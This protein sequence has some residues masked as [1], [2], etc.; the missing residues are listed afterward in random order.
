MKSDT[1]RSLFYVVSDSPQQQRTHFLSRTFTG[2]SV[3]YSEYEAQATWNIIVAVVVV[4]V[5]ILY[6][7]LSWH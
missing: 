5:V 1:L 3:L 7:H 6:Y 2:L 4:F